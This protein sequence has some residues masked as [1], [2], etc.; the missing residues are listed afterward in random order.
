ME[1]DK[2]YM[3]LVSNQNSGSVIGIYSTKSRQSILSAI[4][5]QEP[6]IVTTIQG[7]TLVI[8]KSVY[9]NYTFILIAEK[10]LRIEA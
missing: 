5:A 10:N 6:M 4:L 7:D 2:I 8:N 1:N 3:D 9:R